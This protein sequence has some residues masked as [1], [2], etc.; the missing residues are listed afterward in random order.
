MIV[1]NPP[2]WDNATWEGSRKAQ[3]RRSLALT[4]RQR[5]EA[6]ETMSKTCSWLSNGK[7]NQGVSQLDFSKIKLADPLINSKIKLADPLIKLADPLIITCQTPL[8]FVFRFVVIVGV[9]LVFVIMV[10]PTVPDES[11]QVNQVIDLLPYIDF[12]PCFGLAPR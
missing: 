6:L 9:H 11:Q 12:Y 1:D 3:L 5:F 4:P 2:H 7:M 10:S 8:N